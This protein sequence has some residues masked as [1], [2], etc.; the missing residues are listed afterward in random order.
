M[1]ERQAL[2][3]QQL[4]IRYVLKQMNMRT[5]HHSVIGYVH[6]TM[7]KWLDA[8]VKILGLYVLWGSW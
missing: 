5:F 8:K 3:S 4:P 1:A 7:L 6:I 2:P